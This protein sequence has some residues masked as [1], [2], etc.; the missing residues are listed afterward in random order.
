MS[1]ISRP[2]FAAAL[3]ALAY[4]AAWEAAP[5]AAAKAWQ[6]ALTFCGAVPIGALAWLL[7]HR[8]TGGRWGEQLRPALAPAAAALPVFALLALPLLFAPASIYAWARS[9]QTPPL[10]QDLYLNHWGFAAR[11]IAA[12]AIWCGLAWRLTRRGAPPS[13]AFAALGLLAHAVLVSVIAWDWQ[14]SIDP[15][16]V[17]SAFPASVAI[18]QLLA[19]LG[20]TA[21]VAPPAPP[22]AAADLGALLL[23]CM[24]GLLYLDFMQWLVA[25]YSD[26]AHDAP[27]YRRDGFWRELPTAAFALGFVVPFGLLLDAARRRSAKVLRL[28]GAAVL[29][30]LWLRQLWLLGP[31][32]GIAAPASAVLAC[33]LLASLLVAL[34]PRASALR[35]HRA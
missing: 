26:Q 3:A 11:G 27:W 22:K 8:L 18:A 7:I 6:L 16:Q 9:D 31:I 4:A 30:G 17:S 28:A 14:L 32:A 23:A 19:A 12:L 21:V 15:R 13:T 29:G 35:E 34:G 5:A 20:W 25:W 2:V 33:V 1:R 24:L 10:V